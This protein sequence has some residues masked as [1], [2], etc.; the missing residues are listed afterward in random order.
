MLF[1]AIVVCGV[2]F[3]LNCSLNSRL[4]PVCLLRN[5]RKEKDA[6]SSISVYCVSVFSFSFSFS[7]SKNKKR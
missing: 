4:P 2:G 6:E 5:A 1:S 7:V 3:F